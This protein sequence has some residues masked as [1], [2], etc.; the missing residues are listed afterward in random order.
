MTAKDEIR[1]SLIIL[2][3]NGKELLKR[4]LPSLVSAAENSAG[5]EVIVVDN[6]STDGTREYLKESYPQINLVRLDKNKRFTGGNNAGA[7]AAKGDIIV[8]LNNDV[9][10][11]SDFLEPLLEHFDEQDVFAVGCKIMMKGVRKESGLTR[12]SFK[13]GFLQ[14]EHSWEEYNKAVPI[15]YASGAAFA[16]DREKFMQLGGFD[17]IWD[18]F[19]WEDTDLCY[20]AWKRGWK[21]LFE[22]RSIVYHMHQATNNTKNFSRLFLNL[23]KEAN[24]YLFI[25]KNISEPR[26]LF[27]HFVMLLPAL[28]SRIFKLQ[29]IRFLG[30]FIALFKLPRAVYSGIKDES[31]RKLKDSEILKLT[32][33]IL[34]YK[35]RYKLLNV[36]KGRLKILYVCAYLPLVGIHAGAGRMF[37]IIKRL[38]EKHQ[39]DVISFII[40]EESKYLPALKSIC[41]RVDV[42]KRDYPWQKDSLLCIP[43]MIDEFY[44]KDMAMLIKRR[45]YDEDYDIA[46]FEYLHMSQYAPKTYPGALVLTEHQVHFLSRK[47]DF[48]YLPFSL[49][50]FEALISFLKGMIYEIRACEKFDKVITMT[51]R[52]KDILRAYSK[53][54]NAVSIPMGVDTEIFKPSQNIKESVDI[55]YVGFFR[56]Y[57][58]VEAVLYFYNKIY[59][60]IKRELPE[61]RVNIVGYDPPAEILNLNSNGIKV[62]GY[63][64]DIKPYLEEAKVF[65]MPI[66]LGMGMR[67]KLFEAWA[68]KKAVVSTSIGCEG[69]D[70]EDGKD[71]FVADR[72]QDFA[73]KTV[74]LLVDPSLRKA[75]GDKGREKVVLKYDWD[76]LAKK[77]EGVYAFAATKPRLLVRLRSPLLESN[78]PERSRGAKRG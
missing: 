2:S 57:P 25:W 5:C 54:I 56:H 38:S 68:M 72:P 58:N 44:C 69:I 65:I 73:K 40:E 59:P 3:W 32:S 19:Y 64:E 51:E 11:A 76:I 41:K 48:K 50:K 35:K 55:V 62:V 7:E 29:F 9:E 21:V 34:Y 16:C 52:E 71:L 28:I 4:H 47:R 42:I 15:L 45:L 27:Y 53:K 37:E 75:L 1:V 14:V 61:V 60:I 18:P 66:R 49:K 10:A 26:Y 23:P 24:K 39:V 6:G 67:G 77:L 43:S 36:N 78:H 63:V 12:G 17:T 33:D 30:F 22:P 31:Y 74:A 8:F 46:Q 20:M 70:V 13:R